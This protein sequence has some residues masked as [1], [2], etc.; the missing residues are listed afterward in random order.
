[1]GLSLSL[2]RAEALSEELLAPAPAPTPDAVVAVRRRLSEALVPLAAAGEP[3][4]RL[5]L[6]RRMV[7]LAL[8]RPEALGEVRPC[9]PC[10]AACR[11]SVGLAA[12]ARCR[13][14]RAAGPARAVACVLAEGAEAAARADPDVEAGAPGRGAP[15]P[16][17]GTAPWWAAWYASLA[18][19]AKAV[20]AAEATTWA[21]ELWTSLAWDRLPS[22]VVVGGPDDWWDLPG[23]RLTLRG[24]AEVRLRVEGRQVLVAVGAGA[25]DGSS[26][27]ELAFVG[28]VAALA[29][30]AGSM[31]G[32]VVGLWPAAGQVRV[33][34]VDAGVLE[35]AA[36][37]VRAFAAAW[38]RRA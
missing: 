23:G 30:G 33:L 20:V 24:R 6:D 7:V 22:P 31:P 15:A 14:P 19:G 2:P 27:A 37:Q 17:W 36:E 9:R 32:K 26:R 12:V 18:P 21:T 38:A 10:A 1:V 16:W 13:R 25:P 28:L 3:G 29:G 5:V 11:R 34:P 8:R 4:R 35:A